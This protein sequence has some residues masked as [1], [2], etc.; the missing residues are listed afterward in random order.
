MRQRTS[1]AV[2]VILVITSITVI[3]LSAMGMI[4]YSLFSTHER[5]QLHAL[6]VVLTEQANS[7]LAIPLWNFDRTQVVRVAESIMKERSVYAV[8]VRKAGSG[9]IFLSLAR[10]PEWKIIRTDKEILS[11]GFLSQERNIEYFNETLGKVQVLVTPKFMEEQLAKIRIVIICVIA[12]VA[13]ILTITLNLLLWRI[14]VKPI[15]MLEQYALGDN[16][17]IEDNSRIQ[18]VFLYGELDSLRSSFI[19]MVALLETRFIELRQETKRSSESESRFR[20][21]VNTI[22][23]LIWLKNADGVYLSSN[24]MFERFFGAREAEIVGKTDYDFVDKDLADS[25]RENDRNA[26]AVGKPSSNEEWITFSDDG[27][28]ALLD[29]IKTPMY[30]GENNLIGVLSIGRDITERKRAEQELERYREHLET[31]VEERTAELLAK[32]NELEQKNLELEHFN[33]LFVGRELRMVE[34]KERIRVLERN[35]EGK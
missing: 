5:T 20:T 4:G 15:K 16:G 21:L 26:M 23:D 30:D 17:E 3:I 11:G 13:T 8:V 19:K 35:T 33:K 24:K 14:V 9:E 27:H 29:T 1:I 6:N 28:Q 18:A 2:V 34:L 31:L 12:G 25:S 10:N 22:P 32:S 7:A